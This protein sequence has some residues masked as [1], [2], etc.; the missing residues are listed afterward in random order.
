MGTISS[1]GDADLESESWTAWYQ[2]LGI[3]SPL[4]PQELIGMAQTL[5]DHLQWM[6]WTC[7][8]FLMVFNSQMP[9][10]SKLKVIHLSAND[11]VRDT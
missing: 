3:Q 6:L 1:A 10:I 11:F 7:F 9:Y 2:I 5:P 4:C 8:S